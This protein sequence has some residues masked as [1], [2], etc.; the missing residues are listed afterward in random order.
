MV[1][2]GFTVWYG[3]RILEPGE[4][5]DAVELASADELVRVLEQF[6]TAAVLGK[7]GEMIAV[8][9]AKTKLVNTQKQ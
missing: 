9:L 7:M 2:S 5:L 4:G 8:H 6:K 3:G 1:L